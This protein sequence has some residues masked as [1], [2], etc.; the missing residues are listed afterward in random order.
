LPADL[1]PGITDHVVSGALEMTISNP[2]TVSGTMSAA[3]KYGPTAT[4]TVLKSFSLPAA[5]AT[6]QVRTISFDS[7]AMSKILKGN[8]TSLTMSGGVSSSSPLTVTPKQQV[9]MTNRLILGV[10]LGGGS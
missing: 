6:P 1:D 5:A 3:F 7:T 8:P 2:F 10:R 9:V 4:D